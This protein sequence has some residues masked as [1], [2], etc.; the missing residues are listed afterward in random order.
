MHSAGE[1]CLAFLGVSPDSGKDHERS[2]VRSKGGGVFWVCFV[3]LM[4]LEIYQCHACSA[5]V[6]HRLGFLWILKQGLTKLD[7]LAL[8]SCCSLIWP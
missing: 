4:E 3:Y 5:V 2:D 6:L 7:R 8:N 1:V